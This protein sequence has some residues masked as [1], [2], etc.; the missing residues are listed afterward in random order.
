MLDF[1]KVH[2]HPGEPVTA[3]AWN[4]LVDGVFEAQQA[5]KVTG[6]TARV[7]I[8]NAGLD[9]GSVRVTATHPERPPAEAIAPVAPSLDF[10][11][12]SLLAGAY[13]VNIEAPGFTSQT[14]A[15]T[16]AAD[17]AVSPNPLEVA[18]TQAQQFMPRVFGSKLPA[19]ITALGAAQL[20]IVDVAGKSLPKTG[21]DTE[22][23]DAVVLVQWPTPGLLVPSTG[24]FLVVSAG[25]V[26]QPLVSVPNLKNLTFAAAK[27]QLEA[28]GLKIN[29]I[30]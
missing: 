28:I 3:E 24:A 13:S 11:F 5:L 12:P 23:N 6:A 1:E 17:A 19:A 18:L 7:R 14:H 22:Y 8:T 16:V 20:T 4:K 10:V 26:S 2:V 25:L 21:F 27:A 29:V 9:L 30:S 15:L